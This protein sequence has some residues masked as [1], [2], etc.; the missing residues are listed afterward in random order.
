VAAAHLPRDRAAAVF[1]LEQKL[2]RDAI[3]FNTTD[4]IRYR[5]C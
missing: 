2:D 1:S 3:G 4:Y 5:P